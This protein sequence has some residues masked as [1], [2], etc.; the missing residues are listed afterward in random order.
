MLVKSLVSDF[1]IIKLYIFPPFVSMLTK[2]F[3]FFKF[4]LEFEVSF[5]L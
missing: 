2:N 3:M 1:N 4:K 5:Q